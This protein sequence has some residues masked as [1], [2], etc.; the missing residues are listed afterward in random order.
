[1]RH[2]REAA[3]SAPQSFTHLNGKAFD[4]SEIYRETLSLYKFNPR[5]TAF[6]VP[7][8]VEVQNIVAVSELPEMKAQ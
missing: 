7:L 8:L 6:V 3:K 4:F 1:V 5:A 2:E